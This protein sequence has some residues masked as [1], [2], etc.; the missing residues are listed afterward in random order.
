MKSAISLPATALALA[1]LSLPHLA[2]AETAA[3]T[4][5]LAIRDK[6]SAYIYSREILTEM[7]RLGQEQDEK[8]G[9]DYRCKNV[10]DSITPVN[11]TVIA[12][13]DLPDGAANPVKG[14]WMLRYVFKRCGYDKTYNAVFVA[15][16]QGA[17]PVIQ[18]YYP[19]SPRA[20]PALIKTA[21]PAALTAAESRFEDK[22][23]KDVAVFDMRV[24]AE[25]QGGAWK[26][27]W[28]FRACGKLV[29]VPIDFAPNAKLGGVDFTVGAAKPQEPQ[30][31]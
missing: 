22:T 31:R 6:I 29:E 19:G 30:S 3:T 17:T 18:P 15:N 8:L 23:C 9:L 12:P 7:S 11:A 13:I 21:M 20:G 24:S 4:A 5:E 14:A 27:A 25:S 16:D 10:K 1:V 28:T 26:E 2:A